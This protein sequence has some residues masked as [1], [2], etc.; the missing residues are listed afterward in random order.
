M[1]EFVEGGRLYEKSAN[2]GLAT[3][4]GERGCEPSRMIPIL[5]INHWS[6]MTGFLD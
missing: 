2:L 1:H 5:K 4:D 3:V 6:I